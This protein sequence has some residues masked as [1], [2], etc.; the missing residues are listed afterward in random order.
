ME[1]EWPSHPISDGFKSFRSHTGGL[2]KSQNIGRQEP[3]MS[4]SQ[5]ASFPTRVKCVSLLFFSDT[6]AV[7]HKELLV[8]LPLPGK[9]AWLSSF[10]HTRRIFLM[11]VAWFQAGPR[12]PLVPA[13]PLPTPAA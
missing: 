4:I 5:P 6:L 1:Y 10:S 7:E 11:S 9:D 13:C 12:R 8:Q 2:L 3:V